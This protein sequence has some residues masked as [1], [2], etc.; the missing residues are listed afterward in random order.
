MIS[1]S[2]RSVGLNRFGGLADHCHPIWGERLGGS[3]IAPR[4]CGG[5]EIVHRI[6]SGRLRQGSQ[7][8]TSHN[9][10]ERNCD[11]PLLPT[12]AGRM[13]RA[14]DVVHSAPGGVV[15]RA[16]ALLFGLFISS[17]EGWPGIDGAENIFDRAERS[18]RIL[19]LGRIRLVEPQTRVGQAV[20]VGHS[21]HS[22]LSL[23]SLASQ[24]L[25]T[26]S[27]W[28]VFAT[29]ILSILYSGRNS[30]SLSSPRQCNNKTKNKNTSAELFSSV[31][32][33]EKETTSV[34]PNKSSES[35]AQNTM[36]PQPSNS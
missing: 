35:Q 34:A 31:P 23:F 20:S 11:A 27:A 16:R 18:L 8:S 29:N 28:P 32:C 4:N 21:L 15:I 33:H 5:W 10:P 24:P 26:A 36:S 13:T 19:D 3:N 14:S 9:G 6:A 12:A 2:G 1:G 17:R 30:H 22:P 7:G 25:L